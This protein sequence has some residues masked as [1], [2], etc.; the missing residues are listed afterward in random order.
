[1]HQ[2]GELRTLV[3]DLV[4]DVRNTVAGALTWS[5]TEPS[6]KARRSDM[7]AE[8]DLLALLGQIPFRTLV[9][10]LVHI[11]RVDGILNIFP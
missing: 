1:M 3:M 5:T 4:T 11:V 6:K 2:G 8:S 10:R 7:L 9:K